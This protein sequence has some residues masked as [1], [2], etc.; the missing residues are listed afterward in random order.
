MDT[1]QPFDCSPDH[2]AFGV[3]FNQDG[4][5]FCVGTDDGFRL[6]DTATGKLIFDRGKTSDS[7]TVNSSTY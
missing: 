4:S 6:F 1:R 2:I 7:D 3:E 5:V